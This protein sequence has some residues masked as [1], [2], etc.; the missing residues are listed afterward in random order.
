[1]GMG[2][3]VTSPTVDRTVIPEQHRSPSWSFAAWVVFVVVGLLVLD[4]FSDLVYAA[5]VISAAIVL[6]ALT[7]ERTSVRMNT[8]RRDLLWATA[9][10][11]G[12]VGLYRLA[13]GVF[14]PERTA[15]MFLSY[16]TGMLLGTIG[17]L[18]YMVWF[19]GRPLSALGLG[20][21][22]LRTTLALA[23]MFGAAQFL[24]TL[25]G[26]DLPDPVDWVPLLISALTTGV[27]ESI[28]FRGFLQGR[29]EASF[30]RAAGIGL[31]AVLYG[32]YHVGYGMDLAE[33]V[34]LVG[35]GVVYGVACALTQNVLVLWPL[36]TPL[37]SFYSFLK[38][39]ELTGQLPWIAI[40]G[41][42]DVL[43]VIASVIVF[44]RRH[45]RRQAKLGIEEEGRPTRH[46]GNSQLRIER[47]EPRCQPQMGRSHRPKRSFPL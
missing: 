15:P 7:G 5:V 17:P 45:L 30:G 27:F 43:A 14:T 3:Q 8:D 33:I 35:L 13:F 44:A 36:L 6:S 4:V 23:V 34:F 24:I 46:S 39:G 21:H 11:L 32:A 40:L 26:I 2:I 38:S 19:R 31:A 1:M 28:F 25:W 20:L 9:F 22:N 47:G 41:F 10:Y 12:V 42:L 29:L 18:V 16:A 37:G